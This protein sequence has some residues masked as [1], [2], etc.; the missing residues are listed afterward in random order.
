MRTT[1]TLD[2]D[3]AQMLRL[4]AERGRKPFKVVVN[5]ALRRGLMATEVAPQAG[6]KL[7]PVALGWN[8]TLDPTGFNRL[9]DQLAVDGFLAVEERESS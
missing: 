6:F 4:A 9:A 3:V 1:L 5:E 8:P 2:A 7:Q